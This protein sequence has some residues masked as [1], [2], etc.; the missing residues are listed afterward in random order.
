MKNF[1][2]QLSM[3]VKLGLLTMVS[4]VGLLVTAL[5]L[6]YSQ[7]D[8]S[9][10]DRQREVQH[11]VETASGVLAWAQQQEADGKM[12]REQAQEM[13]KAAVAKPEPVRPAPV[14]PVAK[15][16]E[17]APAA[18]APPI[19]PRADMAELPLP[20]AAD[21]RRTSARPAPGGVPPRR[22]STAARRAGCAGGTRA[23]RRARTVA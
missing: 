4:V 11:A 3:R 5:L 16:A 22:C 10:K 2:N 13:A 12:T 19:G 15:P 9:L 8:Q 6:V 21:D 18:K 7:Y 14:A 20:R 23:C 1:L 17:P